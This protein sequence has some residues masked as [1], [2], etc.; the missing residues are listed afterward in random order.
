MRMLRQELAEL[1]AQQAL[2]LA[3][4]RHEA[5]EAPEAVKPRDRREKEGTDA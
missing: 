2:L 3:R 1:K 4:D 5:H